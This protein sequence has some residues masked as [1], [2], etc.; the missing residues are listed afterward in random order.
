MARMVEGV[1]MFTVLFCRNAAVMVV[2]GN[3]PP[4]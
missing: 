2:Q 1:V 4:T 3:L